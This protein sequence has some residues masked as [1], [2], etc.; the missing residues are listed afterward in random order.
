MTDNTMT[1]YRWYYESITD[2]GRTAG[3]YLGFPEPKRE[4]VADMYEYIGMVNERILYLRWVGTKEIPLDR[5]H[6]SR[7]D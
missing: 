3:G 7:R 4:A 5:S 2:D 6:Y 1:V